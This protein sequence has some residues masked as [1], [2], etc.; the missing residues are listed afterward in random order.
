MSTNYFYKLAC[1]A[2]KKKLLLVA[3]FSFFVFNYLLITVP[4][5]SAS[6][7]PTPTMVPMGSVRSWTPTPNMNPVI[8]FLEVDN[9]LLFTP[10]DVSLD[11]VSVILMLIALSIITKSLREYGKSTIGIAIIYFLTATLVLGA[12]RFIFILDD[13][14]VYSYASVKDIT[15]MTSWHTLFYFSIILFYLAGNTLTKL[16]SSDKGKISYNK[17]LY[18]LIF[19]ILLSASIIASMPVVSVQNFW[20]NHLQSTWFYTFGW[21]HI[22]AL[23]LAV[24]ISIYLYKIRNKFKGIGGMIGDISIAL[25][26]LASIHLWELLNETWRVI[27]VSDDFGEFTERVLWIPVFIFILTSFIK[28]RRLTVVQTTPSD[29]AVPQNSIS[30]QPSSTPPLIPQHETESVPQQASV[31]PTIPSNSQNSVNPS[32]V[33]AQVPENTKG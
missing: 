16:V 13:D 9:D 32:P 1:I 29:S 6:N 8:R 10:I 15:E 4:T 7:T 28:L 26:L 20:V 5:V 30:L 3:L 25:G 12:I 18:L 22:I 31:P 24:I 23:I 11:I 19:P 17:A 2:K 27:V 21:F 33:G 14:S